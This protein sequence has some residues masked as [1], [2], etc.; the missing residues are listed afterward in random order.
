MTP[1]QRLHRVERILGRMAVAGRKA[2]EEFREKI[3]ILIDTQMKTEDEFRGKIK[4]LTDAQIKNQEL[5]H[6]NA[7]A[8]KAVDEQ[9]QALAVAQAELNQSQKLTDRALRDYLN[10][11]LGRGN[12][13]SST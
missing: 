12:G 2:R 1:E 9:V 3:N 8:I 11:Q 7:K 6:E 4:I 5:T 13:N 10:S